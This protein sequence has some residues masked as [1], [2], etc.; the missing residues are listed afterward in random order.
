MIR[1]CKHPVIYEETDRW[2][3]LTGYYHV[4]DIQ[5]EIEIPL[6]H[7]LQLFQE[8]ALLLPSRGTR[9]WELNLRIKI[10][11]DNTADYIRT[12]AV[13][14]EETLFEWT[15][16]HDKKVKELEAKVY[17]MNLKKSKEPI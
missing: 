5:G 6:W 16:A 13:F 9:I 11:D 17:E 12:Y 10:I 7:E 4:E 15:P 1:I 3:Q 8:G 14:G 2:G